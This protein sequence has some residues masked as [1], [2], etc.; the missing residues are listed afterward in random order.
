VHP[1]FD[2]CSLKKGATSM[3]RS[4]AD[5]RYDSVVLDVGGTML[6]FYDREPFRQFLAEAGLPASEADGQALHRRLIGV[7]V[8]RRDGAQG[9]GAREEELV[10]WWHGNFRR[11]WPDRA[12]LAREMLD[13]LYEGRFDRLYDDV[14]PALEGLGALGLSLGVLSN[15]GKHL[16]GVLEQFD[17]LP[18]FDFVV[19]SAEVGLAKPDARIFDVVAG[20]A[21][22]PRQRIL[23]VG[24]HVG[25]DVEGARGAG[26]DAVLI[27]RGN[28]HAEALCPRIA[29]LEALTRYVRVPNEPAQAIILDMDGVILDSMPT[30]LVTWQRTLAPLGIELTAEDLYPLEGVPTEETAKKLTAKFL[31]E[32][33]SEEEARRLAH[34][35]R[36]IFA[37]IFEPALV[38]GVGPLVH[39][40]RGRG[41]RLGLVTGSAGSVVEESLVPTGLADLFEVVV[42]GDQVSQGK[43]HAEPYEQAAAGL[44]LAAGQCL[45]VENAP[46]GIRAAKA[47]GMGC[48]ALETTLPAKRLLEAGADQVFG[49]AGALRAWLLARWQGA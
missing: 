20:K 36:A 8:E 5:L 44:G 2:H 25:D 47:A 21:G 11:T 30:H 16:N 22:V 42:S 34:S 33:C 46:L 35:K 27:D 39:D 10:D 9:L 15:F 32:A 14:I 17:L 12:D 24:D 29:S 31:G 48:V 6:G 38:P 43:P 7:I 41:Y 4:T 3:E 28:H 19:V 13:W 23:Y 40:L 45:V 49:K 37:E 1:V 26:M 18:F